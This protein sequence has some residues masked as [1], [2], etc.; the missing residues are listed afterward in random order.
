M[1]KGVRGETGMNDRSACGLAPVHYQREHDLILA[2][3][4]V[5]EVPIVHIVVRDKFPRQTLGEVSEGGAGG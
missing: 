3:S 4:Q 5:L 1:C 2:P